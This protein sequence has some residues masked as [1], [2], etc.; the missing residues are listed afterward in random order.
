MA[1]TENARHKL[2]QRLESV[3]GPDE[4]DTIMELLPPV[5]WS[6]VAT[7][8]DLHQLEARV[9]TRFDALET[10]LRSEIASLGSELRSDTGTLRSDMVILGS[11][12]RSDIGTLRTELVT[13]G[14]ELRSDIGTLR[15]ELVT[16][17]SELR[18]DM[19]ALRSDMVTQ[20]S[21][22]R[23][24]IGTLRTELT[25]LEAKVD[26]GFAE[27]RTEMHHSLR[28]NMLATIGA[29]AAINSALAAFLTLV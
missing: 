26:V 27:V 10:S 13:L 20:G 14:S 25:V 16:Q 8:D 2:Y 1:V 15:T 18:S 5:G 9:D 7:K 3:I 29:F 4:A 6:Q 17:G 24:D 23:H 11:E 28:S 21:E 12:L 19:E 22:L